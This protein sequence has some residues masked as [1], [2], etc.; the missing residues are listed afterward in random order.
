MAVCHACKLTQKLLYK[1]KA[2]V[3]FRY[4]SAYAL[5]LYSCSSSHWSQFMHNPRLSQD[6]LLKCLMRTWYCI[7]QRTYSSTSEKATER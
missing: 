5:T 7:L 1:P 4:T 2:K 3:T 6:D